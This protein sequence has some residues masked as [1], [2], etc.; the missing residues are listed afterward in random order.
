MFKFSKLG[1]ALVL[2]TFCFNTAAI[3]LTRETFLRYFPSGS[4]NCI[5]YEGEWYAIQILDFDPL[6]DG[7]V[8]VGFLEGP[9]YRQ[10]VGIPHKEFK[11]NVFNCG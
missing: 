5:K 4:R 11:P 9:Y 8:I 7:T 6:N 10:T 1:L 2:S 3:A